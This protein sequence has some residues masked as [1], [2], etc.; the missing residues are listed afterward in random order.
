[1]AWALHANLL[2]GRTWPQLVLAGALTSLTYGALALC[3]CV[4]PA[5][6]GMLFSR[7][8]GRA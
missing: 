6:R 2:P 7:L 3:I 8:H 1:V 5:H 4:A